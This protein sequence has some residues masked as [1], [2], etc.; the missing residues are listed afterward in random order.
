MGSHSPSL[1]ELRKLV[2]EELIRFLG[3]VLE[4]TP[5]AG[6]LVTEI[7]ELLKAGGKR[8]RPAFAYWGF[9]A[10]GGEHCEE[11]VRAAA[12]LELLHSFALVHD[13]IMDRSTERRGRP[14]VWHGHG[15]DAALLVG[16]LA[17]VLADEMLMTSGFDS[18]VLHRVFKPYSR[19]RREVIVGQFAEL[20][21]TT[22]TEVEEAEVRQVARMK[23][24]RY[25]VREPLLI[26]VALAAGDERDDLTEFGECVGEAFQIR[27]DLLG[28][29]GSS[30]AIGKPV[31]SDI[32][33]GKRNILF[34]LTMSRLS[35]SDRAFFLRNWGGGSDLSQEDVDR[36]RALVS[37]SGAE[38]RANELVRELMHRAL[39]ALEKAELDP[40]PREALLELADL[41]TAR[42]E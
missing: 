14:S 39:A 8:L 17:V 16:D 11:I 9:R 29:F 15:S 34:A 5:E 2:D 41:A 27:D 35:G 37:S 38:E 30:A 6:L 25:S 36:I 32:R 42:S 12:S 40:A 10:Q 18:E 21:L 31:D 26:G 4:A 20:E 23:S 33:I 24:G 3:T 7:Q 22:R 28:T 1:D 19:M 13:D